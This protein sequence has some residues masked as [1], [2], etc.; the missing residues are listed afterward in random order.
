MHHFTEENTEKKIFM[1]KLLKFSE[2]LICIKAILHRKS[3]HHNFKSFMLFTAKRKMSVMSV[4]VI[5]MIIMVIIVS[6]SFEFREFSPG[7]E[8]C[9]SSGRRRGALENSEGRIC[10]FFRHFDIFCELGGGGEKE[11]YHF[12]SPPS[13]NS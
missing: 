1:I 11:R 6:N 7:G 2:I 10:T 5:I 12:L 3:D 9:S 13:L 8:F 4:S